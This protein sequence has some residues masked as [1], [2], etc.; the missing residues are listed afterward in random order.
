MKVISLVSMP[1]YS[2]INRRKEDGQI[3]VPEKHIINKVKY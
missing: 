2:K 3:Y 1:R